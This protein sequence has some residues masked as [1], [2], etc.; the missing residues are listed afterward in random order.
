MGNKNPAVVYRHS[1]SLLRHANKVTTTTCSSSCCC[2]CRSSWAFPPDLSSPISRTPPL[3][4]QLDAWWNLA[5]MR[6]RLSS[7]TISMP[8]EKTQVKVSLLWT[9]EWLRHVSHWPRPTRRRENVDCWCEL[10][11]EGVNLMGTSPQGLNGTR[12]VASGVDEAGIVTVKLNMFAL[13]ER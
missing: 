2:C 9:K 6:D 10:L 13:E 7:R 11:A 5:R 12:K 4:N 8:V 3:W 1:L